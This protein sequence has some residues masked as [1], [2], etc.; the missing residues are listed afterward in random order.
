MVIFD[1]A[2]KT[3]IQEF[4]Q[5]LQRQTHHRVKNQINEQTDRWTQSAWDSEWGGYDV[6]CSRLFSGQCSRLFFGQC[7]LFPADFDGSWLILVFLTSWS[8]LNTFPSRPRWS[9][10]SFM[11]SLTK[12]VLPTLRTLVGGIV[13][14]AN[15]THLFATWKWIGIAFLSVVESGTSLMSVPK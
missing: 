5:E 1:T 8:F 2:Y 13:W 12:S 7:S 4:I 15:A 3:R 11:S 10:M 6:P 9:G 14:N